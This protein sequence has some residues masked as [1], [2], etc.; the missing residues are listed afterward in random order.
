[1]VK[2]EQLVYL[3]FDMSYNPSGED[4]DP[5]VEGVF[6]TVEAA[7]A[8]ADRAW[9]YPPEADVSQWKREPEGLRRKGSW[10]EQ[11]IEPWPCP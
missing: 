3:L 4:P 8:K 1:M 11:W 6:A 10:V 5:E 2:T 7:K 9:T